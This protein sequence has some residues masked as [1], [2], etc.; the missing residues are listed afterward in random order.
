MSPG[1]LH[2]I[3]AA[4][5]PSPSMQNSAAALSP[6]HPSPP[7]PSDALIKTEM[8]SRCDYSEVSL[9]HFR[10]LKKCN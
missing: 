6:P 10:T 7:Q 5:Q 9:L 3:S 8:S 4:G 1:R 2:S